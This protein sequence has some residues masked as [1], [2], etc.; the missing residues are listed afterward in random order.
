[1]T[2]FIRAGD[3]RINS[4]IRSSSRPLASIMVTTGVLVQQPPLSMMVIELAS[5]AVGSLLPLTLRLARSR[6]LQ[7]VVPSAVR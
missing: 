7:P 4:L 6:D 2:K 1:V 5:D 3:T